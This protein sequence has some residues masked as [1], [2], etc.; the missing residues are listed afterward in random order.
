M[1]WRPNRVVVPGAVSSRPRL[2]FRLPQ[3]RFTAS[4]C[5][6]NR[7]FGTAV[8]VRLRSGFVLPR[9]TLSSK[10]TTAATWLVAGPLVLF[11]TLTSV[12][13]VLDFGTLLAPLTSADVIGQHVDFETFWSSAVA[14]TQGEDIY[15][16]HAHLR[17]LNPPLVSVLLVPFTALDLVTAYRVFIVLMLFM[18]LG[19]VLAVCRELRLRPAVTA[20]V[21]LAVLAWWP[22]YGTLILGQIYPLLLTGLVAG[23]IAQRRGRPVLAAVL[24]GA[25]VALKPSLAPLLLLA[26][27]QRKWLPFQAGIGA[28]AVASLLGVLCAGPS[29]ARGWLRIVTAEKVSGWVDN[30]SLPGLAVRMGVPAATGMA[31]GLAVLTGTL[32]WCGRHR[33]RLDPGGTAP[34]AVLAA[35]LLLS[36]IAWH[37]YLLVL[38]PGVLILIPLGRAAI[39]ALAL[40]VPIIAV[41]HSTTMPPPGIAAAL[42]QSLY[43]AILLSYWVVLVYAVTLPLPVSPESPASPGGRSA[44]TA[45]RQLRT[46]RHQP[47]RSHPGTVRHDPCAVTPETPLL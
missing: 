17:N 23:W 9:I 12:L 32:W 16:T 45:P 26:A 18:A 15:E 43:C 39:A 7:Q 46:R 36:P 30:A 21:L 20:S 4:G 42:A 22:L 14:V 31:F 41:T 3:T 25:T 44:A 1:F 24:F 34:W 2:R 27:V 19:S 5:H 13:R 10:R 35:A 8:Q 37:N 6:R 11:A 28:A 33:D 40:T 29:S 38:V 47:D